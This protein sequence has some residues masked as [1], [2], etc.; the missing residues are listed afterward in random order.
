VDEKTNPLLTKPLPGTGVLLDLSPNAPAIPFPE[1]RYIPTVGEI[2]RTPQGLEALIYVPNEDFFSG[3]AAKDISIDEFLDYMESRIKQDENIEKYLSYA[4]PK[5]GSLRLFQLVGSDVLPERHPGVFQHLT[6]YKKI[7]FMP[8]D[9]L[10]KCLQDFFP[11]NKF[12]YKEELK[13]RLRQLSARQLAVAERADEGEIPSRLEKILSVLNHS[14]SDV[15]IVFATLF[16]VAGTSNFFPVFAPEEVVAILEEKGTREYSLLYY[17]R[18]QKIDL[19]RYRHVDA[20]VERVNQKYFKTVVAELLTK[21]V[22]KI[23]AKIDDAIQRGMD[24]NVRY[25]KTGGTL[26]HGIIGVL[27]HLTDEE[28]QGPLL[29]LR[30]A[31]ADF[32]ARNERGETPLHYCRLRQSSETLARWLVEN[33]HAIPELMSVSG[34]AASFEGLRELIWEIE[35]D[36]GITALCDLL[37]RKKTDPEARKL[38]IERTTDGLSCVG[39][40]KR[41]KEEATQRFDLP[42]LKEIYSSYKTNECDEILDVFLR[43]IQNQFS[44]LEQGGKLPP[45]ARELLVILNEFSPEEITGVLSTVLP[46][47]KRTCV[48]YHIRRNNI[49]ISDL[50]YVREAAEK[51]SV[52]AENKLKMGDFSTPRLVRAAATGL[53]LRSKR[54][55]N[56]VMSVGDKSDRI[57]CGLMGLFDVHVEH[58]EPV[59]DT[60]PDIEAVGERSLETSPAS[61][62]MHSPVLARVTD[63]MTFISYIVDGEGNLEGMQRMLEE[64]RVGHYW[65]KRSLI[66]T[67][68]SALHLAVLYNRADIAQY[69]M[70][71]VGCISVADE[72]GKMPIDYITLGTTDERIVQLF[73]K[74]LTEKFVAEENKDGINQ[75]MRRKINPLHSAVVQQKSEI[76]RMLIE[77]GRIDIDECNADGFTAV[78]LAVTKPS[79]EI[80]QC[81]VD[82]SATLSLHDRKTGRGLVHLA[83]CERQLEIARYLFDIGFAVDTPAAG[84]L[85]TPLDCLLFEGEAF[86]ELER[87]VRFLVESGAEV[88]PENIEAAP[89]ELKPYLQESMGRFLHRCVLM[90]VACSSLPKP[91]T[92]KTQAELEVKDNEGRTPLHLAIIH[93]RVSIVEYLCAQNAGLDVIDDFGWL[94]VDYITLGETDEK[95]VQLFSDKL[96]QQFVQEESWKGIEALLSRRINPLHSAVTQQKYGIVRE[97]VR[98]SRVTIDERDANQFTPLMLAVTKP[99]VEIARCLVEAKASTSVF[100]PNTGMSLLHFAAC[101]KQLAMAQYVISVNPREV[102]GVAMRKTALGFLLEGEAFPELERFVKLLVESGAAVYPGHIEAAPEELKSY[103]QDAMGRSL[104]QCIFTHTDVFLPEVFIGKTREQLEYRNPEGQTL[105]HKAVVHNRNGIVQHLYA[106]G[107]GINALDN[108]RCRPMN[109]ITFGETDEA[110][111]QLFIKEL[112]L[113]FIQKENLAGI[114]ELVKRGINPLKLAVLHKKVGV[115]KHLLEVLHCDANGDVTFPESIGPTPLYFLLGEGDFP[116]LKELVE[117]LVLHGAAV[118][119]SDVQDAPESVKQF[120]D[121]AYKKQQGIKIVEVGYARHTNIGI[122][123]IFNNMIDFEFLIEKFGVN[124]KVDGTPAIHLAVKHGSVPGFQYLLAREVDAHGQ[125]VEKVDVTLLDAEGV[126]L[127]AR[128][129]QCEN[130][131]IIA[132]W[133]VYL[134][135]HPEV[136]S[137]WKSP[138]T[139]SVSVAHSLGSPVVSPNNSPPV[140]PR[141]VQAILERVEDFEKRTEALERQLGK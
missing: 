35:K 68:L 60:L 2:C 61:S 102:Y 17:L 117:L 123:L 93:N 14:M 113:E 44:H 67:G 66:S 24:P 38:F 72:H 52:D 5:P 78:M 7:A 34:E 101:A 10:L 80:V 29:R 133:K 98:D 126:T 127:Q 15:P 37:Y 106:Q 13:C 42:I 88:L 135:N 57:F 53:D 30:D 74:E 83:V 96:T 21:D 141:V 132:L 64:E 134:E 115:V 114:A 107:A 8:L 124:Q 87:C 36:E 136:V 86:P 89:E 22:G 55:V 71:E 94:P 9:D 118:K 100:D 6:E 137:S 47:K 70:E 43:F 19:R 40:V 69:L 85:A 138:Q 111:V 1:Y 109:Y 4:H 41:K 48:I 45:E 59:S 103:L 82:A 26:V 54:I 91:F 140:S 110:I 49:H 129:D 12:K 50:R 130:P 139:V 131:E 104:H 77:D 76:V 121:S 25:E 99:S 120:L 58:P 84:T 11:V 3:L 23:T 116:E 81:L 108:F 105:L 39:F 18:K 112:E 20:A 119:P 75:L 51:L 28:V 97:L 73:K 16:L 65:V 33:C 90:N 125:A 27:W 46:T 92:E 122:A 62:P 56:W 128:I 32:N 31:G 95:I 79:L 63:P